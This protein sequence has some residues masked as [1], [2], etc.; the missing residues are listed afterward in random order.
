M[1]TLSPAV[2]LNFL[3]QSEA[4]LDSL[5]WI[6]GYSWFAFF[7]SPQLYFIEDAKSVDA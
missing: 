1:L 6:Q 3:K 5:D 7:V 4:Y 2:V